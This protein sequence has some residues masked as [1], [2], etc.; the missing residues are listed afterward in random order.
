MYNPGK[1]SPRLQLA[2][3]AMA[4]LRATEILTEMKDLI[5]AIFGDV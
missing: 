2:S 4:S 5:R 1:S 3:R